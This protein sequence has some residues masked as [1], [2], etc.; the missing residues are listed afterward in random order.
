MAA[1]EIELRGAVNN[2]CFVKVLIFT[3]NI[4][5]FTKKDFI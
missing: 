3:K 5:F 4:P 2:K 1:S